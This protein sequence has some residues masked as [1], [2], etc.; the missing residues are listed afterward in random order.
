MPLLVRYDLKAAQLRLTKSMLK[1]R[2]PSLWRYKELLP[3][4]DTENIVTLGEG[5][6]PFER[7][8]RVGAAIGVPE[9]YIKDESILPTATF[10]SR[11]AAVGVSRAKELGVKKIAMP[12][13]GNAG[14]RS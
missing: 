4:Q 6:T 5:F 10:K 1:Q 12:T 2:F 7:C 11:G 14:V 9:L 3:V 8:G 13:N